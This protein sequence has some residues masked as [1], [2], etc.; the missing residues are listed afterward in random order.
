[1]R[2]VLGPEDEDQKDEVL[3]GRFVRWR[4][5]GIEWEA[6]VKHRKLLLERF[7]LD[8][9]AKAL[10]VNG[11]WGDWVSTAGEDQDTD[12]FPDEAKEFRAAVARLNSL[13][14]GFSRCSISSKGPIVGDGQPN[15]GELEETEE[16]R[17]VS[18]WKKA[19][20]VAISLAV[21]GGGG[22]AEGDHGC[23][24]GWR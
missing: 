16:G 1:M 13:G 24:L 4:S 10:S 12:V 23:R 6:D 11:D 19:S 2:A 5:W 20:C 7:G 17:S 21:R 15:D 3:L 14:S 22:P 9:N 8:G 18:C